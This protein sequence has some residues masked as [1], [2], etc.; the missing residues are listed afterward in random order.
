MAPDAKKI[1]QDYVQRQLANLEGKTPARRE[2]NA[3]VKKVA[4]VIEEIRSAAAASQPKPK[5]S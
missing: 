4:A 1:A 3:A 2:I 5:S